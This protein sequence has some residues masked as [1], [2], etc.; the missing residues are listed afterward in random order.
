L[1]GLARVG[2]GQ[3]GRVTIYRDDWGVPHIYADREEDAYYGLGFAQAED[4][5]ESL[6]RRFLM[7]R[8]EEAR[9]FGAEFVPTDYLSRLFRHAEEARAGFARMSTQ[10]QRNYSGYVAGIQRFMREQPRQVPAWAPRLEP[11]DPVALS[12]WLLWLSYQAGAGI[13]DCQA[14]G[15]RL[16]AALGGELERG[17]IAASNEWIVAPW[18]TAMNAM[19][20]LSDP[21]GGVDGG[22]VYEFRLHAGRLEMAGYSMGA[23]ALLTH[24]RN[25]SWGMTTGAPDVADC[26]DVEVDPGQP[27]RYLFDGKPS[28]METRAERIEVKGAAPVKRI[29]EYTRHNGVLSPVIARAAGKAYVVST[30]YM[31]DAGLFDEEVYRMNLARNVGELRDAMRLLGMFPQNVMA[32]DRDG[33]SY[34]VRAGKTPRR[35][36][37][38]QWNRPVPGNTSGSAWLGIHPLE[39]L[40][41]LE[42]PAAGYMQNNNI[43][44]DRMLEGSP[45][46]PDRYPAYIFNDR[47]GR[48]NSRG[49]RAVEALSGAFAFT[50]EDAID[51]ALDEK[52]MDTDAWL[53]ALYRGLS[54]ET[55]YV[56]SQPA[57]FRR[58][59]GNLLG[60]DGHARAGSAA[61]LQF[62]LWRQAMW[63]PPSPVAIK[64]ARELPATGPIPP[65][66]ARTLVSAVSRVVEGLTGKPGGLDR[67]LGDEFRIGRGGRSFGVGGV[68]VAPANPGQCDGSPE[69]DRMC[70]ATLRAFTAGAP[71]SIGIRPVVAG[72]RLLRLVV[73]TNPIQAFTLHNFGQSSHPD[74]PHYVDQAR[75]TGERR[76]KPVYFDRA[77]LMA[78]VKSERT[79]T[80]P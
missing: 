36:E 46:T 2:A 43:A 15:V 39:D 60:F 24:T 57:A 41:Q 31:H 4:E 29:L 79:L 49:R 61:A 74:S 63:G 76:L 65:D 19:V 45:L 51:L 35:P 66:R 69:R 23:I 10:L 73:F 56:R 27:T 14:G 53:A 67:T 71:D 75:L 26:Y 32:G 11:W 80:I 40:V 30:S 70:T 25:V 38:Y 8:G 72:S 77:E 34:Y 48:T 47:A 5:L 18:R 6:L 55:D 9:A 13:R 22:F 59:A 33:G 50:V 58:V 64:D 12:R 44:P 78:H 68:T 16:A 28:R 1:L 62:W 20:V 42:S 54:Q 3:E 37:G 21:H 52:W 17:A 7:A